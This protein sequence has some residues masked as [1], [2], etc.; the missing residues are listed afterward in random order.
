MSFLTILTTEKL[1]KNATSTDKPPTRIP[2][3]SVGSINELPNWQELKAY[4]K[5][6]QLKGASMVAFESKLVIFGGC[7]LDLECSS[8]LYV[9]DIP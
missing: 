6:L 5:R 2:S 7:D 4:D 8:E 9:F 1:A 3:S